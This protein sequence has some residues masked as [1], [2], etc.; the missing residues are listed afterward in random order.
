MNLSQNRNRLI[1]Q[2]Q[3]CS[4]QGGGSVGIG[5]YKEGGW[6]ERCKIITHGMDKQQGP[7]CIATENYIQYSMTNHNGK[8]IKKNVHM[9]IYAYIYT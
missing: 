5:G 7:Y 3:T 9:Y 6:G 2:E 1:R 4:C 8:N